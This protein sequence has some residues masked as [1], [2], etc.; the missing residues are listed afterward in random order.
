[1][2][3]IVIHLSALCHQKA[4]FQHPCSNYIETWETVGVICKVWMQQQDCK[5]FSNL[6]FDRA[7]HP[8]LYSGSRT[9]CHHFCIT[10]AACSK[11]AR[12]FQPFR[13]HPVCGK[14]QHSSLWT[15]CPEVAAKRCFLNSL[16]IF[17]GGCLDQS[18]LLCNMQSLHIYLFLNCYFCNISP[19]LDIW[20]WLKIT[21]DRLTHHMINV[22][23]VSNIVCTFEHKGNR[24]L[25]YLH[26]PR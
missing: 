14:L 23:D 11:S 4:I 16:S 15:F 7:V 18:V 20:Q 6:I 19:S 1:M 24:M 12:S 22:P 2:P 9:R 17:S 13:C 3:F 10:S 5:P 26:W 21:G 25:Y 8:W